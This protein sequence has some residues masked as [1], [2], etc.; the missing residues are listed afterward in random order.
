MMKYVFVALCLFAVVALATEVEQKESN[1]RVARLNV[2][3]LVGC[4]VALVANIVG[5]LLR[6]IIG[7]VVTL[8][9]VLQIVVGT[10]LGLVATV[11]S[12]ALDVVGSTVGG[13]LNSLLGLGAILSLVE[14]VLHVLLSQALL[15]GLVNAIFA[16]PLSLLVALSTLTDALASAACDCGASATGA[17]SSLAGCIA[18]PN[19]LLFTVGAGASV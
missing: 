15:T 5:G 9:G 12:L 3:G 16:L 13:I 18:G 7:L 17:G 6:V 4:V 19:G 11:A 10:V 2:G 14:E 8:S 1:T